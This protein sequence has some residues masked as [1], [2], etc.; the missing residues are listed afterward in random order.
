MREKMLKKMAFLCCCL[1]LASSLL[2]AKPLDDKAVKRIIR[3]HEK[4]QMKRINQE[5]DK[6]KQHF[7]QVAHEF[8]AQ[9]VDGCSQVA[10]AIRD[11]SDEL[12]LKN[13]LQ[14]LG[15]KISTQIVE[16]IKKENRLAE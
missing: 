12:D 10:E 9:L 11:K 2:L 3:L 16:E 6:Q 13:L 14:T 5:L 4:Q 8:S 15:D 1:S 7:E